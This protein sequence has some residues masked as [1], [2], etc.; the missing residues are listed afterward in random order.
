MDQFNRYIFTHS[1]P[2]R[3]EYVAD[4]VLAVV[5]AL[6]LCMLA[7]AYFDVLVP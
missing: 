1:K 3:W 7:L 6:C 2:S 4:Y 5:L